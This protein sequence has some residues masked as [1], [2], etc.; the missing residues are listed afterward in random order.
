MNKH[1]IIAGL[2]VLAAL[3]GFG[4]SQKHAAYWTGKVEGCQVVV[5]K[6]ANP[7]AAPLCTLQ[8]GKL[9]V[10]FHNIMIGQDDQ[11]NLE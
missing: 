7:D 10:K 9:V 8:N 11:Q 5:N 1:V 4:L 3:V 2:I 6:I